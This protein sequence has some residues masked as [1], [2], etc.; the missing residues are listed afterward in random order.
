MMRSFAY[1][2]FGG[3]AVFDA[4]NAIAYAV[5]LCCGCKTK[6]ELQHKVLV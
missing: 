2:I 6:K 1:S 5:D 4:R 3:A